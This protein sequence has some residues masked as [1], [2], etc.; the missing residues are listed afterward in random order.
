MVPAGEDKHEGLPVVLEWLN[1]SQ[2]AEYVGVTRQYVHSIIGRFDSLSR[3]GNETG[4][5]VISRVEL[6]DWKTRR[7]N[8]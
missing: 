5:L 4:P 2:A 6:D 3:L 8:G 7:Q 1:V